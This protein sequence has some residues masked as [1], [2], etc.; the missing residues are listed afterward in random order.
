LYFEGLNCGESSFSF[1]LMP[2]VLGYGR[3]ES[4]VLVEVFSWSLSKA[5][6]ALGTFGTVSVMPESAG[7][8]AS[9]C[10]EDG[11]TGDSAGAAVSLA[12][13]AAGA[14]AKSADYVAPA[15]DASAEV[16]ATDEFDATVSWVV[17]VVTTVPLLT[18]VVVFVVSV[19]FEELFEDK[20]PEMVAASSSTT[21]EELPEVEAFT[22]VVV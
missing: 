7:T 10:L 17:L 12:E 18:V 5:Q 22:T 14:G 8:G 13:V 1:S 4:F 2:A 3:I 15:V 21:V 19:T 9:F 20:V 16:L 11:A 6:G